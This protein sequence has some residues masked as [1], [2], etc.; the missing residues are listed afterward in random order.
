MKLNSSADSDH[1]NHT[2]GMTTPKDSKQA[3][4][5]RLYLL[6]TVG[7]GLSCFMLQCVGQLLT[8]V[9]ADDCSVNVSH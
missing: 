5:L 9:T 6:S 7:V 3:Q 4:V 8:F 1:M 2:T